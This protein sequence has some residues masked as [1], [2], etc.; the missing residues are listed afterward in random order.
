MTTT[1]APNPASKSEPIT[2]ADLA[3]WLDYSKSA[4][5][6]DSRHLAWYVKAYNVADKIKRAKQ[7]GHWHKITTAQQANQAAARANLAHATALMNAETIS[8]QKRR[9]VLAYAR[10]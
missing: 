10:P 5:T 7:S 1:T 4:Y 2:P 3:A 6:P 9:L 8:A